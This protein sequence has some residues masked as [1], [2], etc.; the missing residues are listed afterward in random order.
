L[1]FWWISRVRQLSYMKTAWRMLHLQID[2]HAGM[3]VY[4]QVLDQI[5]YYVASGI[6]KPGD[7]LPSIRELAQTLA[8]NPTTV[9]RVYG[10]LE[11]E[12]VIEMQHGRGAFV[13]ARS[14]RM[15]SAQRERKIR[16]LARRLVVEAAQMGAPA[17]QVLKAVR[18]ELDELQEPEAT[19]QPLRLPRLARAS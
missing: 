4:R 12:G 10:D 17:S 7:R 16:E 19:E 11:H 3:P 8:V 15:T 6:L 14:F 1:A 13:T 9:V 5:K 18:E 2:A